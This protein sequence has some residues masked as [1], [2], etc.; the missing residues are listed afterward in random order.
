LSLA[1]ALAGEESA[2]DRLRGENAAGH[3][4][5]GHTDFHRRSVGGSGDAH[6]AAHGLGDAVDSGAIAPRAALPEG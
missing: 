4:G 1:G 3:V 6:N 5:G 2:E